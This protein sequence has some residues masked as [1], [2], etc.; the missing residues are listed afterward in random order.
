V[1]F[2]HDMSWF[3]SVSTENDD[4]NDEYDHDKKM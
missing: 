4:G 1:H 3:P 2:S